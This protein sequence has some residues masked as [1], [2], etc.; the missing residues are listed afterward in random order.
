MSMNLGDSGG[1]LTVIEAVEAWRMRV[2]PSRKLPTTCREQHMVVAMMIDDYKFGI[3]AVGT[4]YCMR[5]I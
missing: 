2:R 3:V 4:E 1:I 5:P